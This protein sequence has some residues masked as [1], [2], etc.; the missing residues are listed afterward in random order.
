MHGRIDRERDSTFYDRSSP[1]TQSKV[2]S[3]C[4]PRPA[5]PERHWGTFKEHV[6]L[7]PSAHL[8]N[9]KLWGGG[10]GWYVDR[11]AADPGVCL[12]LRTLLHWSLNGHIDY[13]WIPVPGFNY[14]QCGVFWLIKIYGH[15][16]QWHR[17]YSV[18]VPPPGVRILPPRWRN[19]VWR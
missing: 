5:T 1:I 7:G 17:F 6:F 3:K 16:L 10:S 12:C 14:F 15:A 4:S 19:C 11:P 18:C 8:L 13:F 2:S 9:Q